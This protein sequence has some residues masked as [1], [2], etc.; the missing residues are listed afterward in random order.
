MCYCGIVFTSFIALTKYQKQP[1]NLKSLLRDLG[2]I[3]SLLFFFSAVVIATVILL[4]L[5]LPSSSMTK[6]RWARD[7]ASS[8]KLTVT[9]SNCDLARLISVVSESWREGGRREGRR[10][11]GGRREGG[12]KE[13]GRKE[14]GRKEGGRKEGHRIYAPLD[15]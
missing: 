2:Q 4:T 12:R 15:Y 11:E 7:L 13:G 8:T 1:Q 5:V 6:L 10:R 14:G 3:P 9:N